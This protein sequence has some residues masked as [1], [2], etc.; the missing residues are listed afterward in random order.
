MTTMNALTQDNDALLRRAISANSLFCFSSGLLL[1]I[2]AYPIAELLGI[3]TALVLGGMEGLFFLQMTA[4]LLLPYA[5]FL[6]WVTRQPRIP[7]AMALVII[8]LDF[9][10]TGLS[11][12]V[13]LAGLW[14]LTM[15]GAIV[16]GILADVV[17]LFG[18]VQSWAL[19]RMTRTAT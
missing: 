9:L 5:A 8:V 19:R 17:A 13:I 18:I 3:T 7:A 2:F 14:P 6:Y 1:L 4:T 10:W 11:W 16:V 12:L 15:T